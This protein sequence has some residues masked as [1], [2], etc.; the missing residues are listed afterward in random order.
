MSDKPPEDK[1]KHVSLDA[2]IRNGDARI[3]GYNAWCGE[4]ID[5]MRKSVT[6]DLPLSGDGDRDFLEKDG[7]DQ[8]Q[9]AFDDLIDPV[10]YAKWM[11]EPV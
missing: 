3:R 1:K 2:E 8:P 5:F 11:I 10:M 7:R 4:V 6:V 9:D